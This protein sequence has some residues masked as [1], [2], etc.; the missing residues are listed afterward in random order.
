MKKAKDR[1]RVTGY[2]TKSKVLGNLITDLLKYSEKLRSFNER[3]NTSGE[4]EGTAL[5]KRRLK[6][7]KTKL[8]RRKV[9]LLNKHMFPAMANLTV[10]LESMV[11]NDYLAKVFR[12]DIQALF[13]A[14]STTNKNMRNAYIFWRFANAICSFNIN[15]VDGETEK[16][17]DRFKLILCDIMQESICDEMK[18]IGPFIFNDNLFARETL[19]PDMERLRAWTRMLAREVY[20]DL[21]FDKDS[22]PALF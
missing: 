17:V 7:E 11:D 20:D 5:E 3:V 1:P 6:A 21:K 15:K 22:R 13:F 19:Y 14:K 9:H 2:Y 8:N 4:T 18:R 10:L 16:P 12:E